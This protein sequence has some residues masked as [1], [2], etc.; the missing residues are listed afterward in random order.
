M[1]DSK[2]MGRMIRYHRKRAGPTR[3]QLADLCGV[4]K[5]AVYDLENG[6]PTVRFNTLAAVLTGLNIAPDWS[7]PLMKEFLEAEDA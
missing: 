5:T 4:G 3:V 6:K 1:L 7:S 2:H